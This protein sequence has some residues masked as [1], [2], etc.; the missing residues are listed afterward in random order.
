MRNF[1]ITQ[2]YQVFDIKRC[3]DMQGERL[4]HLSEP[5]PWGEASIIF[6]ES[7]ASVPDIVIPVS[8]GDSHSELH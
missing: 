5:P 7:N 4:C 2:Y 8:T 3:I 6:H 1:A